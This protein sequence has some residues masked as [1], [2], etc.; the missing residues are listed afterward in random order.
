M[1]TNIQRN[2]A[3]DILAKEGVSDLSTSSFGLIISEIYTKI[4]ITNQ[5]I[6]MILLTHGILG[7]LVA[8]TIRGERKFQIT[9]KQTH[10]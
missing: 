2:E 10:E 3:T 5:R 9:N 8:L 4:L 7:N 6:W 1:G